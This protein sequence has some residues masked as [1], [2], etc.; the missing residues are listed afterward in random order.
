MRRVLTVVAVVLV[1]AAI[2]V[3]GYVATRTDDTTRGATA[4]R[5]PSASTPPAT[6]SPGSPSPRPTATKAAIPRL[7]HVF[8]IVMENH[9]AAQILHDPAAASIDALA[10]RY[11]YAADY[12]AVTHPSLP[13]Y[14]ALTSGALHG[15]TDDR[16]PPTAGYAVNAVNLADRIQAAG[17]TW[18]AYADSLPSPGYA[19]NT[20]LFASRH[21]PFLYYT[22]ILDNAARRTS[23]IVPFTRMGADLRSPA[24]TP[25]YAFITPNLCH[26][27]HDCP[28]S[29]G[30]AWLSRVVPEILHS[31]AFT[32]SPSLLAITW[33]EGT[34]S[35]NHVLTILAG[36][37]VKDHYRSTRAYTHYSLLHTIE[38]A[39]GL[40]P[41]TA[42]DRNAPVM[43]DFFRR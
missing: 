38:E 12:S 21:E 5:S 28:V 16:N 3:A 24:T 13:N 20:P 4:P 37:S 34:L 40:R 8:V 6:T 23:H 15:I 29:A 30:N 43:S 1:V 10:R 25:S 42:N 17:L 22:D 14:I 27:M 7:S 36:D 41:L 2:T 11:A 26:D 19:G 33:D 35:D 31:K 18:K 32:S 9:S 39:L